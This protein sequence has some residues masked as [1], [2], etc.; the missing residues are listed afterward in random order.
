M[1]TGSAYVEDVLRSGV[2]S[3]DDTFE[4]L[5]VIEFTAE[6]KQASIEW[7]MARVQAPKSEGGADLQL[8]MMVMQHNKESGDASTEADRETILYIGASNERLLMSAEVMAMKKPHTDGFLHEFSVADFDNFR[9]SGDVGTFFSMAE[10]QKIILK[11]LEG[12]RAGEMD[13]HIPG[14]EQHR[15]YPGKSIIKKYQSRQIVLQLFPLHDEEGL[16]TLASDWCGVR[17]VFSRQPI[18]RIQRYF[19]EKIGIYFAFLGLYTI[20]LIPPALIGVV[21]F[22]TSW[23]SMYRETIFAVFNLIWSTI[24]LEAWK[25]YCSELTYQWGS[26][27][28]VSSKFEEPRANYHGSLG[29]NPVTQKPEPSFPKWKR[30]MRF[31]MITVPVIFVCLV[32]AFFVM[33]AYFWMQDWADSVYAG[34]KHWVNYILLYAPTAVYAVMIGI[35]N[36]IYRMVAKKL[37]DWENHRLQS[38]YDNHFTI[39]LV[40]FDFVN[41]FIS[42]F[43]VAFYMQDRNVLHSHLACLLITSQVVGQIREAIVPFFIFRRR[44][45]QLDTVLKKTEALQM[46]NGRDDVAKVVQKQA[47]LEATMDPYDGPMDD[48]LEL[49]LQFG[50][51]YLFSSAFP[52]AA[53][54][55]LLNNITEIRTDAFKMCKIFQRPFSESVP[56]IGAWQVAFEIIGVISVMTNCA[57]IGM[58]PEVQKLMPSNVTAVNIV[59]IFVA[60]EHLVLAVKAA[61]AF[62]I[63]D[64]PKWVELQVARQEYQLRQGM[65]KERMA[66]STRTKQIL[67]KMIQTRKPMTTDMK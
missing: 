22:V 59:L 67:K 1:E 19:G 56:N 16:K 58:D 60:V 49:F 32:A 61:V 5:V 8:R 42:L 12:I 20:S 2:K 9:G 66:A 39:K 21:Y 38:S 65:M 54:W 4:A 17:K 34:D 13:A 15:L 43:Y 64:V 41:C 33:L 53:L 6:A 63:P 26:M 40:L 25:R 24:F 7:L 36:G 57:L 11:E 23:R 62:F 51:V 29:R 46:V 35:L 28:S 52:L 47:N 55:A 14:Y 18:H 3:A 27:D 31:Y 45:R 48:Y 50:Y 37:N 10:K 44:A 30:Q